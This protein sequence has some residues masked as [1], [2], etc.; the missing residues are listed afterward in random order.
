MSEPV[1]VCDECGS[2][3]RA[4]Q[5]RARKLYLRKM[6]LRGAASRPLGPFCSRACS[7]AVCSKALR[8]KNAAAVLAVRV[9]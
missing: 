6:A 2:P 8:E 9:D 3:L 5:I 4:G 1:N 7:R